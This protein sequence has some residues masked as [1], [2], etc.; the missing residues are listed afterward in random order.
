MAQ[1]RVH[2]GL[3]AAE[4]GEGFEGRAGA[5]EGNGAIAHVRAQAPLATTVTTVDNIDRE[6]GRVTTALAFTEQLSGGA[7]RYGTG[8]TATSCPIWV[9]KPS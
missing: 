7:G 5:A 9:N 3:A 2:P 8:P 1:Q 6:I 4:G